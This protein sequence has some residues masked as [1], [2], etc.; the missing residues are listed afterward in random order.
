LYIV[1][2]ERCILNLDV[3]ELDL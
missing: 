2:L 1:I 3:K